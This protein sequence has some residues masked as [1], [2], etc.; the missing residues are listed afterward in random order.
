MFSTSGFYS[1]YGNSKKAINPLSNEELLEIAPAIG[2]SNAYSGV[3]D[4]Y[5]F[6]PTIDVVNILRDKGWTPVHA[7]QANVRIEEKDGYQKHLIRF[8]RSDLEITSSERV[9]LVLYNSH[10]RGCAFNLV[11]SVWRKICSNGLMVSSDLFNYSHRH[12]NFDGNAFLESAEKI[13]SGA[14]EI[15]AQVDNFKTIELTPDERGVFA[16]AALNAAYDEPEKAPIFPDRLLTE[17]RIDDKGKD[18]WTTYNV[19]QEN[20]M[21]GGLHGRSKT[22][23]KPQRTRKINSIDKDIKLNKMLWILTTEMA[24]L[25]A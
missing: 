25:K 21:K 13:V 23:G 8:Q 12:I 20:L 16:L 10:D 2:A 17:R 14:G 11:A 15:A 3:S 4:K 7:K 5:S 1:R 19:I 18:L 9:D 22:T 24:K 6:I